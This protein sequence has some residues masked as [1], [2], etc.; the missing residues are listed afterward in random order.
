MNHILDFLLS[1]S[2]LLDCRLVPFA[3]KPGASPLIEAGSEAMVLLV[4]AGKQL[5]YENCGVDRKR[6]WSCQEE[7]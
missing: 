6:L 7:E 3:G 5:K 1:Y 2:S 4:N